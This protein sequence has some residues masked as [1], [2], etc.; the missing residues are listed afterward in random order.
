MFGP[1]LA[2]RFIRQV[3]QYES[4]AVVRGESFS[5]FVGCSGRA[6]AQLAGLHPEAQVLFLR[7]RLL[8]TACVGQRADEFGGSF[9]FFSTASVF[10][11]ADATAGLVTV[12]T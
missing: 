1:A 7:H 12:R 9:V 2:V 5:E 11:A 4:N 6:E 3:R 10:L 8:P